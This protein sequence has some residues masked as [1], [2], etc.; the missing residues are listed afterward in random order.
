M[1]FPLQL[2]VVLVSKNEYFTFA[3]VNITRRSDQKLFK[4]LGKSKPVQIFP[5]SHI[6]WNKLA[7]FTKSVSDLLRFK[8]LVGIELNDLKCDYYE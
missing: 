8:S 5:Q 6:E 7:N 4:N 2:G 1:R 3:S